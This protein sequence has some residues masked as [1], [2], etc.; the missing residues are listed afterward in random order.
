MT[1][2][3]FLKD[4][5]KIYQFLENEKNS[6]NEIIK[7]LE[8][9]EFE[10]LTI[11]DDFAKT[12][13]LTLDDNLR[14]AL[15]T[16]VVNLRDDSLVQVLKKLAKKEE[17]IITL[18]EK[19]YIFVKE[20]WEEKHLKLINFIN[21]NRLLTP[22]YRTIFNGVF[23][24][25]KV[26]STWQSSWTALIINK[27][28]KDLLAK[29]NGDEKKVF[30]Y[31]ENEKLFDLG[32]GGEIA[33]R[34][35][36]ALVKNKDKY[37]SQAYIKAFKKEV[38]SVV[39]ALENF[40]DN[41]IELEDEI[42]NQ[43]WDYILYIQALIKAFSEDDVNL[44]VDR[45][46]DVDRAWMKITTPIQIGHPLEYYED[47]FRKAVALEWDIRLTNPSFAKNEN[48][49]N[50]I[51]AAFEK[52]YNS[53]ETNKKYEDIYKF[54]LK[55]LDK[56]QL[57]IG[58][59]ALFF[60]A[61]FNGLFSAQVVPNDE[62][63]SKEEGK[64]IFAF[65]DEILQSSRAKPFLRL[66]REIFGQELL[67]KDREFLFKETEKWHQVYDISTIGHEFGHILW[68]DNE[69][70]AV[71]NKTGNFKN[72]EEF[73]ATTGGLI[74]FFCDESNDEKQLE[75]QVLIDLVKRAVGLIGWMEVDE[76]QP[77]YC[78]GLIHL[79]ALFD[80]KVLEFEKE[81]LSID[82]S[83]Q[84]IEELKKWYITTYTN[85]AKHYLEKKDATQFLNQF[86]IKEEKYFMPTNPTINSFV[87]FYFEKYKDIGQE[88][89]TV[90]KK[91]NYLR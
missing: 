78:E 15:V 36:S 28:N 45:W 35:Y 71:M 48:R 91:S 47:H 57:Y 27:T 4:V 85:L 14:F 6:I 65:S 86:A 43:K 51:K 18:Q 1:E 23:S 17:E 2:N 76:V 37:E 8:N 46:A 67:T 83:K 39:D 13:G 3:Q 70:E 80:T 90:D 38:T 60:A 30:E 22:F 52:I 49:V 5:E 41:L 16:R 55:S 11:I 24:V 82:L 9:K 73:K 34:C 44:L 12:L 81:V 26:M 20:F 53:F 68:C 42:Y 54:S 62:I 10:K 33:D 19:A 64:K 74:S 25:G 77:Y 59:P 89:D 75:E 88:L 84:K 72:I 7:N 69:T 32:H 61:G 40:A 56:V 87:K 29:F 50:K 31:L 58:R 66:S 79:N 21:E 63:V